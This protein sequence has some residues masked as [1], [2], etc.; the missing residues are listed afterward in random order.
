M[1]GN[2]NHERFYNWTAYT[3]R[4]HMPMNNEAT[5]KSNGGFW[6]TFSY[7]NI[8]W[9]SL[10]SEHPLDPTSEQYIFLRTVLTEAVAKRDQVP[11]IIV[12]LHKPLYCSVDG[13][14]S[15]KDE[16]ETILLE[17]DVDLTITGHMHAYERIHPVKDGIVTVHPVQSYQVI[18]EEE[19]EGNNESTGN[20]KKNVKG[21]RKVDTYYAN[22]AG[23]VHLMQGHAG[24]MQVERWIQ[25]QPE[26]SA[27]RM[28][29]GLIA[30]NVSF[31]FSV[32]GE[33]NEKYPTEIL[34]LFDNID[35]VSNKRNDHLCSL[36]SQLP[37]LT[38]TELDVSSEALF[39]KNYNYSHTYGFGAI[40]AVNLTHL[41]YEMI[42]N[43]AGILN[44][45][46][47]WIVKDHKPVVMV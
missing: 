18:E 19:Q 20:T 46:A 30:P 47:F 24:G 35:C 13:S 8:R 42:P 2:G 41:Y 15:F 17:F 31:E 36:Y 22:G 11:C 4:Y 39:D 25:P 1:V 6:Y 26:W 21:I 34:N 33:W 37:L 32:R 3:N 44:H 16:L 7:G 38:K 14:P 23:P 12:T 40:K 28:A 45:D 29:N 5:Y 9:I 27:F 43:V 10:S